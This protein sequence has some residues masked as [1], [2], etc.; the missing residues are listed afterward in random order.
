MKLFEIGTF[1]ILG[2]AAIIGLGVN[3]GY[4]ALKGEQPVALSDCLNVAVEIVKTETGH[5]ERRR[6]VDGEA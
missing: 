3:E 1:L 2:A 4:N 5:I 6:C